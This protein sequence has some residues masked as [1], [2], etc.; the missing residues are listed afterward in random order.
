MEALAMV[1][2][3]KFYC[4]L[5]NNYLFWSLSDI[6]ECLSTASNNCDGY[7]SCTN[8]I[9]SFSCQCNQGFTGNGTAC[10]GV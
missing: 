1:Y 7:A 2:K 4:G 3:L 10:N 9:G 5:I 6:D 8:S